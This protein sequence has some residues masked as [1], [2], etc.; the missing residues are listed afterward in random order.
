MVMRVTQKS[1]RQTTESMLQDLKL[2]S[3]LCI[4]QFIVWRTLR[5][6]RKDREFRLKQLALVRPTSADWREAANT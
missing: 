5:R 1:L 3:S 6:Q 2:F 4:A